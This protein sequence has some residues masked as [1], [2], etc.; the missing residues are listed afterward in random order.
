MAD[1]KLY[2]WQN[3]LHSVLLIAGML[4]IAG[5][6]GWILAGTSGVV[7][8]LLVLALL[9]FL[10]PRISGQVLMRMYRAKPLT[11]QSAPWLYQIVTELSRRAELPAVPVI[12]R[13]PSRMLNAFATGTDKQPTLAVTDGLLQQLEPRE[14]V[15][16]LAHEISHVRHKDLQVMGMADLFSRVTS[17]LSLVGQFLLL[18]SLPMLIIDPEYRISWAV[19]LLLAF[20]PN[21]SALAQ[22]GLSR[23]RE[24][25]A[26]RGA[27]ELCGD[28]RALASALAKLER[29][30][31][32]RWEQIVLPGR[33][34]PDPSLLR[35]HPKTE[36]RIQ[37]LLAMEEVGKTIPAAFTGR[38][39]PADMVL[40]L[41]TGN[42]PK[43][44]WRMT[45]LWY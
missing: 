35:T 38:H 20:S 11:P 25:E 41:L 14:L 18:L 32:A 6:M 40:T 33:K 37:R 8:L 22:L 42:L 10:M 28:P 34:V 45:G 31:G 39:V 12:Y 17:V 7:S 9:F 44:R 26:D 15:A 13:I 43:P 2:K 29:L 23:T 5:L 27:V 1:M 3:T 19:L 36:D 4:A 30:Q 24:Y 16:V 21:L